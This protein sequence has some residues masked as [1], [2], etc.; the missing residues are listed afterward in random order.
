V[1]DPVVL[2]RQLNSWKEIAGHFATT[3]RTVQRWE[4]ERGLPIHRLPGSGR[5]RVYAVVDELDAW[6]ASA[7]AAK[8]PAP[9]PPFRQRRW[10]LWFGAG[11]C[12]ACAVIAVVASGKR[13]G[14]MDSWRVEGRTLVATDPAGREVWRKE[15]PGPLDPH[16]PAQGWVGDLNRD[17]RPELLWLHRPLDSH[18][19]SRESLICYSDQGDELW[20]YVPGRAVSTRKES[21]DLP[22]QFQTFVVGEIGGLPGK[23]IVASASHHRFYPNQVVVLDGWGRPAGEYWHSGYLYQ[24]QLADY[25]GDGRNE[26]FLAGVANGYHSATVTVLA[27]SRLGGASLEENAD[28]QLQGFAPARE[29]VRLALPRTCINRKYE[30]HAQASLMLVTRGGIEVQ[31]REYSEPNLEA[32]AIFEFTRGMRIR[33]AQYSDML[34]RVHSRLHA[35]GRLDHDWS[36]RENEELHKI[37][38]LR[39]GP[40]GP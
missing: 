14:P 18:S 4:A 5:S 15:S 40:A 33:R 1:S 26:I 8:L 19:P 38:Y 32:T 10:I 36:P 17:G 21:F 12:I 35:Q 2:S 31:T 20:R 9:D 34:I 24:V 27:G 39:G 22:F 28:H 11:V 37:R 23:S 7:E 16:R 30:V 6:I 25:D 29:L 3:T 13:H